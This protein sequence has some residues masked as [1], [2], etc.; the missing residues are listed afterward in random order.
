ME[1]II[2]SKTSSNNG[3]ICRIVGETKT[4]DIVGIKLLDCK[5]GK[6]VEQEKQIFVKES[7]LVPATPFDIIRNL[8][9]KTLKK[10]IRKKWKK[11]L[12][13]SLE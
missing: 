3:K 2:R 11:K 9:D 1:Y 5:D 13:I 12:G 6:F 7:S 4:N 8:D 10:C